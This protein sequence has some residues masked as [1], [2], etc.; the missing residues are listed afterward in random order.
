M[1]KRGDKVQEET[2]GG[3]IARGCE[4]GEVTERREQ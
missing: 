1:A 3:R 4:E 2:A